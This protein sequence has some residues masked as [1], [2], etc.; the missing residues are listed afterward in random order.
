MK[1]KRLIT[2]IAFTMALA[3]CAT[4][5]REPEDPMTRA[6]QRW[7]LLI[8]GDYRGAYEYLT[9]GYKS[10]VSAQQ[11]DARLRT[12]T[13][14]WLS[15]Q[16]YPAE[17]DG[18]GV[19]EVPVSLDFEVQMPIPGIGKQRSFQPL[20]EKWLLNDGVWYFLPKE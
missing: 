14:R 9:P 2:A 6:Q 4:Q 11:Y 7:D 12:R 20:K 13:V 3:G 8:A 10:T 17:C 19:C 15:A 18:E 16:A 5:P 1:I